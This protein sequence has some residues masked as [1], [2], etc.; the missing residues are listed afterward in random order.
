MAIPYIDRNPSVRPTDRKLAIMMFTFFVSSAAVDEVGKP[1][2]EKADCQ[3]D[4]ER[5]ETHRIVTGSSRPADTGW[6]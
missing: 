5:A 3:G 6:S 1:Q 2:Q 4:G